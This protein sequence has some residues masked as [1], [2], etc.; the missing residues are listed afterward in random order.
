MAERLDTTQI[1]NN[2][3]EIIELIN[4]YAVTFDAR[5]LESF[6]NLFTE[7]CVWS[8][9]VPTRKEPI[10]YLSPRTALKEQG[11]SN[12]LGLEV[13]VGASSFHVQ[14]GTVFREISDHSARTITQALIVSQQ[15]DDDGAEIDGMTWHAGRNQANILFIGV[16]HDKFAKVDGLWLFAERTFHASNPSKHISNPV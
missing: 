3:L 6:Y 13:P 7:D 10:E 11:Y 4:K 5:D 9:T 2:K 16:Y 12:F 14:T 1:A 8:L 15:F